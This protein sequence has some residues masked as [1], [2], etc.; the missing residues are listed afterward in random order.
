MNAGELLLRVEV[1]SEADVVMVHKHTRHA[2][3]LLGFDKFEQTRIA[4]TTSEL[5]RNALLYARGGAI[6]L[7]V[8]EAPASLLLRVSDQGPGITG[9][10]QILAGTY[11]SRT[12]LGLGLSGVR[13]LM[14][15]FH[16]DTSAAGT[17]VLAGKS[18]PRRALPLTRERLARIR[19]ELTGELTGDPFTEIRRLNQ[20]L[21]QRE[22]ALATLSRELEDTN[23]GVVAL[24]AELDE[25][26]EYHRRA[27][28]LK[29]RLLSD[30]GHE[31]RT[32]VH[33]VRSSSS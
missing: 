30:M 19:T 5:V 14:E 15:R 29:T 8:S 26:A 21:L 28:E 32:P 22:E 16:I 4:T 11:R 18:L 23:R 13:R 9:L 20:E 2:T 31:I 12:G 1:R 6:E 3:E 7:L 10:E 25:R 27:T 33:S 24:Y 17:T